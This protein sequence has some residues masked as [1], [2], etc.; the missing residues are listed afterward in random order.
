MKTIFICISTILLSWQILFSQS[1][2]IP[3]APNPSV[4]LGIGY[5]DLFLEEKSQAFEGQAER[6]GTGKNT[7]IKAEKIITT[8]D[9]SRFTDANVSLRGKL[10]ILRA[11]GKASY[12]DYVTRSSNEIIFMAVATVTNP[13]YILK[14]PKPKKIFLGNARDYPDRFRKVYGNSYISE[15]T[16]GAECALIFSIKTE[17]ESKFQELKTFVS[18]KVGTVSGKA[19][20]SQTI[21]ELKAIQQFTWKV[22]VNGVNEIPQ[23]DLDR[24]LNYVF[25]F[26]NLVT[27]ENY[28]PL[29]Y[30]TKKYTSLDV[31]LPDR[32]SVV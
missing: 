11:K 26:P 14:N 6:L 23:P 15:V 22:V 9:Y 13:K 21:N 16:T 5:D 25:N 30:S 4:K 28:V 3:T 31:L 8:E 7:V 24:A 32:K 12:K 1:N 17:S 10:G 27:D 29:E 20:F 19:D 2:T 18:G